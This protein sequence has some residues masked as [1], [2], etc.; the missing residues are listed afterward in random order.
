[1]DDNR[2][3]AQGVVVIELTENKKAFGM[4][5]ES[6]EKLEFKCDD[7][8]KILQERDYQYKYVLQI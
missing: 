6:E 3:V 1:M 2:K 7:I 5:F 8:Y 4:S